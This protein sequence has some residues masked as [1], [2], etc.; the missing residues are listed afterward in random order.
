VKTWTLD[1]AQANLAEIVRR[2]LGNKP[3]RLG[4]GQEGVV[5]VSAKEYAALAFARD[6]IAFV[7]RS[8]A[9]PAVGQSADVVQRDPEGP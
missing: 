2:A 5:V 7:Q 3:Q 9:L 1:E 6:L 8:G 4:L